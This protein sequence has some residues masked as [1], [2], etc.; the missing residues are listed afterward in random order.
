MSESYSSASKPRHIISLNVRRWF[1]MVP[2]TDAKQIT[3]VGKLFSK[4]NVS[5]MKVT[6]G[7]Y[8][9]YLTS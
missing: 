1:S 4:E 6:T 7:K 9:K 2:Q 5:K 3:Y 8:N